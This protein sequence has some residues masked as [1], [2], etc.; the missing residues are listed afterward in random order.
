MAVDNIGALVMLTKLPF[1]GEVK[2]RLAK[3]IGGALA[4]DLSWAMAM[5][6][7]AIMTELQPDVCLYAALNECPALMQSL[8][9]IT[10]LNQG[11]GS[12][13]DRLYTIC[14]KVLKKHPWVLLIG[15]DSPQVSREIFLQAITN[16]NQGFNVLGP[17]DDGG[18]Y[19]Q[20]LQELPHDLFVDIPWSHPETYALMLQAQQNK[21]S[22]PTYIL[23]V[24]SDIDGVEDIAKLKNMK[25]LQH[26]QRVL[27]RIP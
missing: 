11:C 6:T 19:M 5:D 27:R 16:M 20:G 17:A 7:I 9:T 18:Y 22:E 1:V 8:Q 2:T 12:L 23:P 15:S 21:L 3:N 10:L 26:T 24:A 14:E 13:G 4:A 25:S